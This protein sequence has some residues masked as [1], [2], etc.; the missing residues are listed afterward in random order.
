MALLVLVNLYFK[1]FF[2]MAPLAPDENTPAFGI[3]GVLYLSV[4]VRRRGILPCFYPFAPPA[5]SI[6]VCFIASR[7]LSLSSSETFIA[8]F[9]SPFAADPA[10]FRGEMLQNLFILFCSDCYDPAK[11]CIR[12][13][14]GQKI[15]KLVPGHPCW[16]FLRKT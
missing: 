16:N 9:I 3:R 10:L 1:F 14:S 11:G 13:Y 4:R 8:L 15:R 6:N 5:I 7:N 2:T 12:A